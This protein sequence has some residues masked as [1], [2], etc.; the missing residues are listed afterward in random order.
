VE[1]P[2]KASEESVKTRLKADPRLEAEEMVLGI[3]REGTRSRSLAIPLATFAKDEFKALPHTFECGNKAVILWQRSTKSAAAYSPFVDKHKPTTDLGVE[4]EVMESKSDV[5]IEAD[6]TSAEAPFIDRVSGTRFDVA[7]HGIAGE[8]K[9]W[10]LRP[11]PSVVC[12]WFAWAAE[13]P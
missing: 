4:G 12:K 10:T 3:D 11:L 2:T 1:L 9:G 6:G 13:Y 8:L 5:K 7:G